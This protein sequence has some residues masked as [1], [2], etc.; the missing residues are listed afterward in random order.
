MLLMRKVFRVEG[1][2]MRTL[3]QQLPKAATWKLML[4]QVQLVKNLSFARSVRCLSGKTSDTRP[5]LMPYSS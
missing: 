4:K 1:Q 5:V 2:M 3:K